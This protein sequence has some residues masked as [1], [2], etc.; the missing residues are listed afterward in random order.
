MPGPYDPRESSATRVI[1]HFKNA[2]PEETTI[3]WHG[4]RV[5]NDM[6]GAPGMTQ[7]PIASGAEFR[8]EF[9]SGMRARIGTT[10]TRTPRPKSAGGFMVRSWSRTPTIPRASVTTW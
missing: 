7:R 4:V 6:D 3:H 8:Y 5:P 2:L 1:V 10:R 9:A